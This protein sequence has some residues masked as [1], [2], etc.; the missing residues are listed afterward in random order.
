[1]PV[2]DPD[3]ATIVQGAGEPKTT[4]MVPLSVIVQGPTVLEGRP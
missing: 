4:G 2:A 3:N 1:M